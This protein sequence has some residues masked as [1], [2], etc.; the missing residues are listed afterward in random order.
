M[1]KLVVTDILNQQ[2]VSKSID[3]VEDSRAWF[4][5]EQLL[6]PIE[7]KLVGLG[8]EI[9]TY[10]IDSIAINI[11]HIVTMQWYHTD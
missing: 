8:D 1:V 5:E 9:T 7:Q 6:L 2:H 10:Q 4:K 3:S 11:A